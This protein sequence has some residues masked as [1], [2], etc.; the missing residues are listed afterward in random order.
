M[1]HFKSMNDPV[2]KKQYKEEGQ[3]HKLVECPRVILQFFVGLC[4]IPDA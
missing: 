4:I 3:D 2:H 1:T